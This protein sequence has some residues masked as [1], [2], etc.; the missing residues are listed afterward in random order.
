MFLDHP[1]C[2]VHKVAWHFL[3]RLSRPSSKEGYGRLSLTI[4]DYPEY[5]TGPSPPHNHVA[6]TLPAEATHAVQAFQ[7]R[8]GILSRQTKMLPELARREAFRRGVQDLLLE[9]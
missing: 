1:G 2:A 7:V 6:I 9:A 5:L 3:D 8:H 4:V